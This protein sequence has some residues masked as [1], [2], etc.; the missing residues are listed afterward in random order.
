MK[1]SQ[2]IQHFCS[3]IDFVQLVTDGSF[4]VTYDYMFS[5]AQSKTYALNESR[6]E[7]CRLSN[8][9]MLSNDSNIY[10]ELNAKI[11]SKFSVCKAKFSEG[12]T[13]YIVSDK[14]LENVRTFCATSSGFRN[15]KFF[16]SALW[17][18]LLSILYEISKCQWF[19][20]SNLVLI[21]FASFC[22]TPL[23]C[24]IILF[25]PCS[26]WPLPASYMFRI[27][28]KPNS[29]LFGQVKCF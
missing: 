8:N 29:Q 28:Q 3:W 13:I 19:P 2:T 11:Q 4:L 20:S 23:G 14:Y 15:V 6:E 12:K 5:I 21:V 16:A 1:F 7:E 27:L 22:L 26:A 17:P 10:I 9:C 24:H 25:F 18:F